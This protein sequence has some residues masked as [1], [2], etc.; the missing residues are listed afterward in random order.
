MSGLV[1]PSPEDERNHDVA[2]PPAPVTAPAAPPLGA[3]A[4]A[5]APA[6]VLELAAAAWICLLYTSP[7]PRD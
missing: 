2:A 5:V 3:P 6:A 4:P 1:R 7:S